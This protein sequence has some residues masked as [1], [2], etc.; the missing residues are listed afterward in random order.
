MS[1]Y[2][3]MSDSYSR[4]KWI[5][6]LSAILIIN[7]TSRYQW[8]DQVSKFLA[9]WKSDTGAITSG[10]AADGA[11]S[12]TCP[13]LVIVILPLRTLPVML[14]LLWAESVDRRLLLSKSMLAISLSNLSLRQRLR[15]LTF[16]GGAH[17]GNDVGN[18]L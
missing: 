13:P 10:S 4:F 15:A 6:N 11:I 8:K 12:S 1:V 2:L 5:T 18:T 3:I 17:G 16:A 14:P 9:S 7:D